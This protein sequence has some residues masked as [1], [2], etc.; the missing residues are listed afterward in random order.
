MQ[1]RMMPGRQWIQSFQWQGFENTSKKPMYM[2]FKRLLMLFSQE[3]EYLSWPGASSA[4]SI[5]QDSCAQASSSLH[6][7]LNSIAISLEPLRPSHA[8]RNKH[9]LP[10]SLPNHQDYLSSVI[11]G[12]CP[13][14][15][16]SISAI[17]GP[18]QLSTTF[19]DLPVYDECGSLMAG[20]T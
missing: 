3:L 11:S 9:I 5:R 18:F 2:F 8:I 12:L 20:C 14:L 10:S 1:V 17:G 15:G 6:F 7:H 16:L 13:N 4:I 19:L